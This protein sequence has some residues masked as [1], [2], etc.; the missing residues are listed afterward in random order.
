VQLAL[1]ARNYSSHIGAYDDVFLTREILHFTYYFRHVN[2]ARN[3]DTVYIVAI[4]VLDELA[5]YSR[6]LNT[7]SGNFLNFHI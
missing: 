3:N 4:R 5:S 1:S 2:V 6:T 7:R